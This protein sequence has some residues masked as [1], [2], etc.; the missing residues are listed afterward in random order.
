[1][2]IEISILLCY[3][4]CLHIKYKIQY[5]RIIEFKDFIKSITQFFF[6]GFF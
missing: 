2:I 4:N 3:L 1:M 5:N 6:K